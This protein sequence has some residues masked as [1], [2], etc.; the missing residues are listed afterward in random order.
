VTTTAELWEI[1]QP[2]LA[3]EK[4][5]LD[6]VELSG[7]GNGRVLRV[8]VEGEN[9]D[10]DRL[11]TLSRN[12]SRKLDNETD[13]D[14]SYQLEVTTPGLERKLRRPDQFARA[15]GRE[16]VAKVNS[17]E[18]K[19]TIRGVLAQADVDSFTVEADNGPEVFRYDD[20]V[21]ANT[22]FRWEKAPKPGH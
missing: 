4:L 8:A 13:I 14:G 19:R 3:A 22:V 10:I 20:V 18:S 7:Q 9:V 16:I 2:Y 21:K 11:S 17:S 1:L 12:L 15:V 5:E 6:D